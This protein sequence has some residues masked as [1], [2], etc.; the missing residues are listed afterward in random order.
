MFAPLTRPKTAKLAANERLRE[1]AQER[2]SGE[3]RR[4]DGT[5]V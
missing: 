2:L 1:Y 3:V 4:P 5:A